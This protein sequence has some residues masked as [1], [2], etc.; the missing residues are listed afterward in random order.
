MAEEISFEQVLREL[1]RTEELE[2]QN[3]QLQ[4]QV[5]EQAKA[6]DE[7]K[8]SS[9]EVKEKAGIEESGKEKNVIG[10]EKLP[11]TLTT[12]ERRRYQNIGKEFIDGAGDQFQRILKGVKFKSMMSTMKEKFT[13]GIDKIKGFVKKAKEK[14]WFFA[15]LILIATL[16]GV[17]IHHFKEKIMNVIP[18]LGEYINGLFKA[19]KDWISNCL[20]DTINW[21]SDGVSNMFERLMSTTFNELKFL[22]KDFFE[23]T[24]PNAIVRMYLGILSSFSDDA[25]NLLTE[26]DRN[27]TREMA[28]QIADEGEAQAIQLKE[29]TDIFNSI[30]ELNSRFKNDQQFVEG[31]YRKLKENSAALTLSDE[32]YKSDAD[33]F[34]SKL[35]DLTKNN[36]DIES[37][38]RQG[39]INSN[40]LF[41]LLNEKR[42]DGIT[43]REAFEALKESINDSEMRKKLEMY[44]EKSA[45]YGWDVENG[46]VSRLLEAQK[47]KDNEFDIRRQVHLKEED[48]KKRELEQTKKTVTQIEAAEI[49]EES[50]QNAFIDLINAIKEF[51]TGDK[52]ST[53]IK[54]SLDETNKSFVNFFNSFNSF[55]FGVVARVKNFFIQQHSYL[56]NIYSKLESIITALELTKNQKNQIK[57][58]EVKNVGQSDIAMNVSVVFPNGGTLT[59][60]VENLV[61]NV[62]SIDLE[63]NKTVKTANGHLTEVINVLSGIELS[64]E[65]K[66]AADLNKVNQKIGKLHE[67]DVQLAA[68]DEKLEKRIAVLENKNNT[69]IPVGGG[70]DGRHRYISPGNK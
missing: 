7:L 48:K 30:N 26:E 42:H 31:D 2:K 32:L 66:N 38:I 61:Q 19:G 20:S 64:D 54:A 56:F 58:Y 6:I 43:R 67:M 14:K 40:R 21:L 3:A 24:L 70:D 27:A 45:A 49:I 50:L 16:L 68:V 17:I 60:G 9:D 63:L 18:N 35:E 12:S 57:G 33:T 44:D 53:Q 34:Y 15:K 36:D 69:T 4:K 13:A 8:K 46:F 10:S 5:D 62:V 51:L 22:V 52:I 29:G 11:A 1:S 47:K 55:I 59:D 41:Q 65:A 23:I 25:A 28:G 39:K 37:L